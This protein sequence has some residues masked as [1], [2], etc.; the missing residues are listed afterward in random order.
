MKEERLLL[1]AVLSTAGAP[2]EIRS[3]DSPVLSWQSIPCFEN[4]LLLLTGQKVT[5]TSN[6]SGELWSLRLSKKKDLETQVDPKASK[7]KITLYMKICKIDK[8][9]KSC[10]K[11]TSPSPVERKCLEPVRISLYQN[12]RTKVPA[13]WPTYSF[14]CKPSLLAH[15]SGIALPCGAFAKKPTNHILDFVDQFASWLRWYNV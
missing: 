3:I 7:E 9:L 4:N 12:M 2:R 11:R 13:S 8:V 14:V 15:R 1:L 5:G 6:S 10:E